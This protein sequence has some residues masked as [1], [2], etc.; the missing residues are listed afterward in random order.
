M[1]AAWNPGEDSSETKGFG[2]DGKGRRAS[3]E[4]DLDPNFS[5]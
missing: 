1:H 2:V 4:F 5:R 3:L